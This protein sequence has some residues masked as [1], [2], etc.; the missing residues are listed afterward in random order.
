M[1]EQLL[2]DIHVRAFKYCDGGNNFS[3]GFM[4]NA[5]FYLLNII[6]RIFSNVNKIIYE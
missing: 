3:S 1:T 2:R 4:K 6:F 5:L